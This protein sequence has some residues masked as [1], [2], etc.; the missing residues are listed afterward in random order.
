MYRPVPMQ[1]IRIVALNSIVRSLVDELH[2][3]GVMEISRVPESELESSQHFSDYN[4]LSSKI[5]Q[6]R[7]IKNILSN[8]YKKSLVKSAKKISENKINAFEEELKNLNNELSNIQSNL[9]K[10]HEDYKLTNSLCSLDIDFSK[11]K[12]PHIAYTL[13]TIPR[14]NYTKL[15]KKLE[16]YSDTLKFTHHISKKNVLFLFLHEEE[17][18][19][20]GLINPF[21]F[22]RI[23]VPL[24]IGKPKEHLVFLSSEIEKQKLK[25]TAVKVRLTELSEN[26]YDS[27]STLL[28][29]YS[30][31]SQRSQIASKFG[32][33]EKMVVMEGWIEKNEF[34]SLSHFL[35]SVFEEKVL[36]SKISKPKDSPPTKLDNPKIMKRFEFF[37]KL[38]SLPKHSEFDPTFL[39]FFTAPL[40]YGMI[41]GDVIYGIFSLIIS[42]LLLK[43][44]KPKGLLL[45]T[46]KLW[47]ISA[48]PA[49]FFGIFFDEW[50]AMTHVQFFNFLAGFGLPT[51][52]SI[53]LY[54][55]FHR[56][57]NLTQLVGLSALVGVFNLSLGFIVGAINEW[58]HNKKHAA[59]KLCWLGVTIFGTI[60]VMSYLFNM[61]PPDTIGLYSS[62]ILMLS[63]LGLVITEGIMG[64]LEIPGLAGNILSYTRIAAVG[65]V[66]VILAE[67]I[68]TFFLPDP[69]NLLMLLVLLPILIIMHG[70]NTLI[71][72]VEALIQGGRLNI[73]EFQTKFMHGG[74]RLFKPFSIN[75]S[76]NI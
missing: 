3:K 31:L 45:F 30:V 62:S 43:K 21:G 8:Y 56:V 41:M 4:E 34:D 11:L 68:N 52:I 50:M 29:K 67:I 10:F 42:F 53:P 18:V 73:V 7:S 59:A 51:L 28:E 47:I 55:G 6:I 46:I 12:S 39:F 20:D 65:V 37:V 13:G 26:Y 17:T 25:I 57:H 69:N 36:V 48:I 74:G 24:E 32:F 75:N 60:A 14:A 64:L 1:K 72:M 44:L 22:V 35:S 40:F 27:I 49:I 16:K 2:E 9:K 33:S 38:F 61:F 70:V 54:E 23:S 71:V 5:I 63:I 76:E 15:V 58:N 19:I 66:G